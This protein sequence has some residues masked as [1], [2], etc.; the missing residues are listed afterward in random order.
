[1]FGSVDTSHWK[2]KRRRKKGPDLTVVLSIKKG[3]NLN[4]YC[5][6]SVLFNLLFQCTPENETSETESMFNKKIKKYMI[7]D[8]LILLIG[9]YIDSFN[10]M[11]HIIWCLTC[12]GQWCGLTDTK[13][14]VRTLKRQSNSK[15]CTQW[16]KKE[17]TF[18]SLKQQQL[19]LC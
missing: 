5:H 1:M 13:L 4:L 3:H 12:T 11:V 19:K 15:Y 17:R 6:I 18:F 14:L 16:P 8:R 2:K 7:L 10:S 9:S